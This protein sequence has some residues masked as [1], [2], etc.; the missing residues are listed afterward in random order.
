MYEIRKRKNDIRTKYKALREAI[1]PEKKADMDAKICSTFLGL[2]TYRYASVLLMYA[3]KSDEVN[4][5]PIAE[6]ALADGKKVA[7]PRCIPD[8]HDMEYHFITSLDQLEKGTYGLLEPTPDLPVYDRES[9]EPTACIVPA[10]VYDKR[11]FRLGYGKGY[12]DRYLGSYTGSKVGMIYSEF[13]IDTVPRGRFDL[14][15]DFIVTERGLK[16][17]S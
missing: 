14:S 9:V 6:R 7:F 4:I 12:Y 11:G 16:V 15:V 3:P 10:L 8:T 1:P 17:H 13:I 5:M 2:A